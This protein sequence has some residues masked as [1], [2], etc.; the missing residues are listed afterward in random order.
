MGIVTRIVCGPQ[1]PRRRP[2]ASRTSW[3]CTCSPPCRA[4]RRR[5]EPKPWRRRRE[6][7]ECLK[8]KINSLHT[9]SG[10]NNELF[11]RLFWTAI[12]AFSKNEASLKKLIDFALFIWLLYYLN[13]ALYTMHALIYSN[14]HADENSKIVEKKVNKN[15][16]LSGT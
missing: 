13:L 6:P 5:Q 3:R 8:T 12:V 11:E 10:P 4:R 7:G 14:I 15:L 16:R 2:P 1:Y 9:V